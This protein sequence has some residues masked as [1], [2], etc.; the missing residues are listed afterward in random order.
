MCSNVAIKYLPMTKFFFS[1]NLLRSDLK[2][3]PCTNILPI[4]SHNYKENRWHGKGLTEEHK[5]VAEP[6]TGEDVA[7]T[8]WTISD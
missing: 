6:L 2:H 5:A 3:F 7:H 1:Y 4:K 8:Q